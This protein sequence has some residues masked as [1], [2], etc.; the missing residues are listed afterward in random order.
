MVI[1]VE[2]QV[3]PTLVV[4]H[5]SILQCLMAYF[6]NTPV[7][8]CM[9]IEVPMH[10]VIKFEPARGGGW[11]ESWHPLGKQQAPATQDGMVAVP[12][13]GELS[14]LSTDQDSANNGDPIWWG[15]TVPNRRM[16][17]KHVVRKQM[18]T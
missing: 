2:Q 6:R 3:I 16:S 9:S 14:N 8:K 1:D 17:P 4:S 11:Q 5:V 18:S 10:T 15:E 7:E 13:S 12:S